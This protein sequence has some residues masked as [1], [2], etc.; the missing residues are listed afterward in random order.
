VRGRP[1]GLAGRRWRPLTGGWLDSSG[2]YL[3]VDKSFIGT[4]ATDDAVTSLCHFDYERDKKGYPEAHLQING[5]SDALAAWSGKPRRE[6]GRL[7]F[8]TGGRRYRPVL[9]DFVEFLIVEGLADGR[10]GW[11]DVLNAEREAY[12][13]IQLRAAIRRD[14]WSALAALSERVA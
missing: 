4:Y 10:R 14:P 6:L 11:R 9:E 12:R 3:E 5:E 1:T 8:P 2:E 13:R 7:H